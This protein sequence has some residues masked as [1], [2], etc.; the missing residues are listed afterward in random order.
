MK[1]KNTGT[2]TS[3]LLSCF[4]NEVEIDNYDAT[5]PMPLTW[6]TNINQTVNTVI[7]SGQ[8][9]LYF[10]MDSAKPSTTLTSGTTVNFKIHSSG[11]MDYIKLVE[12]V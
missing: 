3:T 6:A 10:W 7:T 8:T 4:I 1:L 9:T 12:L 2:A 5:G 11:G